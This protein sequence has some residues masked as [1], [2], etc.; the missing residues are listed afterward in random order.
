MLAEM[1][2]HLFD[3]VTEVAPPVAPP[4][5]PAAV[6]VSVPRSEAPSVVAR[7][8]A[9]A[10]APALSSRVAT[11]SR[12]GIER[13]EWDALGDAVAGCRAC[14]LCDGRRNTVF[15]VGDTQADWLV[16]GEAP[17]EQEDL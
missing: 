9:P 4:R 16:V 3:P 2:V 12:D 7:A 11:D 17:G 6:P 14:K 1:G 5:A 13:M 15:G 8:I 10:P